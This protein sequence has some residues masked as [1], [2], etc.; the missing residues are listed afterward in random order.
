MTLK[1]RATIAILILIGVLIKVAPNFTDF[2]GRWWPATGKIVY[3][4]DIQGGVHLVMG[5]DTETVMAQKLTRTART[6]Q[7][8]FKTAGI[9][10]KEIVV[11]D[12]KA[13]TM[14]VVLE[15]AA[16]ETKAV[17][18]IDK[19]YKNFLQVLN[20]GGGEIATK[21]Y[22]TQVT[23][24]RKQ[25]L[26]QAIGVIR[27]R[28]DEFGV[29]EPSIQAQ[30]DNRILV[31]LPGINDSA[32]AK[33]LINRT[34]RLEF[35]I[36]S[37]ELGK[38]GGSL[39]EMITEAET[40]G[41]FKLTD[42]KMTYAAYLKKLNEAL[43]DKLPANTVVAFE[44]APNAKTL[45]AGKIPMLLK[46]DNTIGGDL[47]DDAFVTYDDRGNPQVAFRFGVEGG[48]RFGE[49][50]EANIGQLLAI[51]LDDVVQSAPVIQ[52]KITDNGVINLNRGNME[53][54]FNEAKFIST[55]L[56]AGALPAALEQLEER[57]VGPTLGADAIAKA[58][59]S[60]YIVL[61]TIW[62]F[63]T[64][65][66]GWLGFVSGVGLLLNVVCL[67]ALLTGLGATL[68]LPG[69]AGMILTMGMAI[70]SNVIIFERIRE[71]YAKG[72]SWKMAVNDGFQNAYSAIIDSNLVGAGVALILYYYGTGPVR[73]FAVTMLAGIATSMYTA[74]FLSKI[75]I[76]VIGDRIH[77]KKQ[78][79]HN[80][81]ATV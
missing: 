62:I 53:E 46:T 61:L 4:L 71:E 2:G 5:I 58:K 47:L 69:V 12:P 52:S 57:T 26:D 6:L 21:V 39:A 30:G 18:V 1:V 31:Q 72:S 8:E 81:S 41:G 42:D 36:V 79:A 55:T 80:R 50:T 22:E 75:A 13:F 78:V 49:L 77:W 51:V 9:G 28:I 24:M 25:V 60:G 32:N 54:T 34:A 29:A 16:D 64:L 10:V 33:D 68:T 43:K 67:L 15:S 44:K 73:G 66:Y 63:M 17:E 14:K 76:E 40:K 35:K 45:E 27:N 65:Y 3:G 70:D 38:E 56:R 11:T 37:Q 59:M 19:N 48:R 74:V 23:E 7:D 20:T